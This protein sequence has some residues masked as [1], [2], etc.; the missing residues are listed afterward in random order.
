MSKRQISKIYPGTMHINGKHLRW[1]EELLKRNNRCECC[2]SK[3]NLQPH[4]IVPCNVYDPQFFDVDNGAV[5]C[6]S[7]HNRYHQ[8]CI[9]INRDTLE[10]FLKNKRGTNFQEK[11]KKPKFH[12]E[13]TR[14]GY[15]RKEYEP[16]PLY[17]KIRINDFTKKE[18][19][20]HKKAKKRKRKKRKIKRFNPIYLCKNLGCDCYEYLQKLE[21]EREILG[22]F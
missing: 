18:K 21:L 15:Q 10:E 8:T 4:H 11:K 19:K 9:P 16:H 3:R 6:E 13:R 1:F 17:S 5:L 12:F 22:D 14:K 20:V 7:C 2:G